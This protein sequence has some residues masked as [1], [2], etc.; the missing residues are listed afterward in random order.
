MLYETYLNYMFRNYKKLAQKDIEE[1]FKMILDLCKSNGIDINKVKY[2]AEGESSLVLDC[3][4]KIIKFLPC[5]VKN[6]PMKEYLKDCECILQPIDER[7]KNFNITPTYEVTMSV[8]LTKKLEVSDSIG[9]VDTLYFADTLLHS[10]YVWLD[11]K[12]ENLAYNE[13]GRLRLID[14]G[15]LWNKR[16]DERFSEHKRSFEVKYKNLAQKIKDS[17]K[18]SIFSIFR[19]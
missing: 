8:I 15:E 9:D 13:N 3:G 16:Y 2:L 12:G 1:I 11:M 4:D 7:T 14:Y 5:I 17:Q 6:V 10:G 18:K 19:H